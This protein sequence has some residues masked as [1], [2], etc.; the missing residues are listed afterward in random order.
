[1]LQVCGC[2]QRHCA[3]MAAVTRISKPASPSDRPIAESATLA[4]DAKAKALKAAG[5]D[6]IG[7]GAGEPDFPTPGHIV[8][9]AVAACRDP[10]NHHY[11]PAG[12]PARAARGDRRQDPAR[13]RLRLRGRPGARHQ[14]RQARGVHRV[15]RAVRPGRRGDLSRPRTGRP[16]PRRSPSP[17]A[18]PVVIATDE[19]TGFRVTVE[20]LEAARTP[21]TKVAALRVARQPDRRGVPARARSRPSAAGPSSTASGWSPTRSTSTSSTA[22]TEFTSMPSLVPELADRCL[23]AQRRGQDLR[24]DR[25]ARRLDD[26][27]DR[28]HR[29]GHQP[30]VP[31]HLERGQRRRQRA[32]LAAVT[33]DLDGRGEMRDGLRPPAAASMHQMLNEIDGVTCLEPEGAFYCFPSVKGLLGARSPGSARRPRALEL[34]ELI[35]ER[36]QGGRRARRGVRHARATPPVVRP[37]RRR[38]RRGR[39]R[40][41]AG[42][43]CA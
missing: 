27:P 21:R 1:M 29:G 38:P 24:H 3:S 37:R 14:R 42:S 19:A 32:A 6:V 33:G 18:S 9:A 43:C 17:A 13:L 23:V 2:R 16:T 7:F 41:I 8:E 4:V 15:R 10:T 11:T 5:E 20:Q 12:G 26:R 36:G 25:V 28:R 34:A 35:L 22:S 31:R 30:P 39:R 40:G